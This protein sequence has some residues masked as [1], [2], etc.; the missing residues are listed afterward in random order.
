MTRMTAKATMMIMRINMTTIGTAMAAAL[1]L[2]LSVASVSVG[3][4][5]NQVK[6]IQFM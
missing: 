6:Q 1:T 3:C 5:N 4:H 2:L